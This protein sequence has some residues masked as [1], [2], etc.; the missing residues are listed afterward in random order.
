MNNNAYHVLFI[1]CESIVLNLMTIFFLLSKVF[2]IQ[3][4]F[5]TFM[6]DRNSLNLHLA[7]N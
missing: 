4:T 2:L 7:N 5:Q 3:I 1:Y 6:Y